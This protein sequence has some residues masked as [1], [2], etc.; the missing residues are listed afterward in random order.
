MGVIYNVLLKARLQQ[1][2]GETEAGRYELC[3]VEY[4]TDGDD[5]EEDHPS[6]WA[7]PD[8]FHIR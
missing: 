2:A 7:I 5:E 4:V 1:K 6:G 8:L 3:I